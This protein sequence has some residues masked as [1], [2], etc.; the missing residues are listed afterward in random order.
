[1]SFQN[2]LTA[3]NDV[4]RLHRWHDEQE[5]NGLSPPIVDLQQA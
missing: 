1:M 4:V 2:Y 3:G 5:Q